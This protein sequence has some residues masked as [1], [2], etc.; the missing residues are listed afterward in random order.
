MVDGL[1]CRGDSRKVTGDALLGE[2]LLQL[3]P[4]FDLL[5]GRPQRT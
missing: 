1:Q 5:F 4:G 3:P 2:I